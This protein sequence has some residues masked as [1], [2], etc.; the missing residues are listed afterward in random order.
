MDK[1]RNS[2]EVAAI[3][4]N[5]SLM[6]TDEYTEIRG[7]VHITKELTF[8]GDVTIYGDVTADTI[9]V[10]GNMKVKGNLVAN[11][12]EA[13]GEVLV[14]KSARI[15]DA[16]SES[17]YVKEDFEST[18]EIETGILMVGRNLKAFVVSLGNDENEKLEDVLVVD[19]KV[20]VEE[21]IY[22]NEEAEF[23]SEEEIPLSE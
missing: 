2:Y 10:A 4:T 12:L 6:F 8:D 21:A 15:A 20:C 16:C 13:D 9:K 3:I 11:V 18:V 17:F 1:N 23:I 19:G 5:G 14:E 22:V 7:N